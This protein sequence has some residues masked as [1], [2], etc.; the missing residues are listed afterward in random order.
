MSSLADTIAQSMARLGP[1]T[2]D[3]VHDI[4]AELIRYL[5]SWDGRRAAIGPGGIAVKILSKLKDG[6]FATAVAEKEK[7]GY[8]LSQIPLYVVMNEKAPLL[9][10]AHVAAQN[11]K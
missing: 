7:L 8:L 6:R 1:A 11:G 10:A 5:E 2:K 4:F 9:G 3:Q